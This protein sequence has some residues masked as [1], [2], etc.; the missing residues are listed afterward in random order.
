MADL[1]RDVVEEAIARLR[2]VRE[3]IESLLPCTLE[4]SLPSPRESSQGVK[5]R[6]VNAKIE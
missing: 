2:S 3:Q 1:K 6:V 4:I 5:V